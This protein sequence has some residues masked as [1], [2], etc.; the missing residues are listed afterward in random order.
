MAST[1]N[2][3][4][5]FRDRTRE[6]MT[7]YQQVFGGE[8]SLNTYADFG[9]SDD[10]V[11]RDKI[12]HAQLTT[13]M[14]FVLMGADVPN[15]MPLPEGGSV[16]ISLSGRDTDELTAYWEALSASGTV[17]E[18]LTAAPWGDSFGECTDRFG[19]MWLVNIAGP[20]A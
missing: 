15:A 2:P 6:A 19:I 11:E 4:L 5:N 10:P 17:R 12:M 16:S 20:D 7:F 13:P 14:G 8:L 18:P 9:M 3:Y 1:L